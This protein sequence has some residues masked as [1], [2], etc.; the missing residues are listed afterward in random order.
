MYEKSVTM[1]SIKK[2]LTKQVLVL[3]KL[4]HTHENSNK[5]VSK[6]PKTM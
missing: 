4:V 3:E 6:V 5:S 2:F 1:A